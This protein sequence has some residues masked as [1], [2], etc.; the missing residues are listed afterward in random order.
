MVGRDVPGHGHRHE[1]VYRLSDGD[2]G[3][4]VGGRHIACGCVYWKHGRLLACG[5]ARCLV[6]HASHHFGGG[7]QRLLDRTTWA[8][9]HCEVGGVEHGRKLAPC[10]DFCTRVGAEDEEKLRRADARLVKCAQRVGPSRVNS[11]SDTRY[12]W[13]PA[14]ARA[15]M[16]NRWKADARG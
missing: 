6:A 9:H 3:A 8:R 14:M 15:S 4:Y 5:R 11:T 12:P 2:A 1:I 10:R 7:C 16:A 13:R